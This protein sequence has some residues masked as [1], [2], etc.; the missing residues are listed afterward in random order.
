L[1]INRVLPDGLEG[2]FY[3][4][5]KAQEETYL[6]EI[7]QRFKRLRRVRIR[8]LPRDVYGL[9]SLTL[10]SDQLVGAK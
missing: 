10:I 9:A 6:N 2:E 7:D 5:R 4:S 8:Q 3:R 1:I